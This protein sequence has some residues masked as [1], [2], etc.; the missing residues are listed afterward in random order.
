MKFS[1]CASILF[2]AA[3]A[4]GSV[5]S[6]Y[7]S[8]CACK[9]EDLDFRINCAND[10]L[11]SSTLASLIREGCLSSCASDS[12]KK[13]FLILKSHSDYC[14]HAEISSPVE[15]AVHQH[16]KSCEE[17]CSI[18]RRQDPALESCPTAVCDS[19]GEDAYIKL[20]LADCLT[21]CSSTICSTNYKIL[22]S[23]Y[24]S[25][26][27]STLTPDVRTGIRNMEDS[28]ADFN[29]NTL[30]SAETAEQLICTRTNNFGTGAIVAISVG[31]VAG[32]LLIGGL[33]Y[34]SR[35]RTKSSE[36]PIENA[37]KHVDASIL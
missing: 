3:S 22:R 35:K 17:G 20:L 28:C 29:C 36:I 23:V 37:E 30:S 19:S 6:E 31:S 32:F 25:C 4:E 5:N 24:D 12:C 15:D 27:D 2:F 1:V 13:N 8:S 16:E 26:P 33:V 11:M 9:A 34:C 7:K 21:D 18:G 14:L 10:D